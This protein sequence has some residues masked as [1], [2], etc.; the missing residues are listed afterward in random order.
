VITV[1]HICA[2]Y[3]KQRL[4]KELVSALAEIGVNQ[5]ILVPVRTIGEVGAYDVQDYRNVKVVYA[6][7]L[8]NLDRIFFFR[9]INRIYD[10][11]IKNKL[12]EGVDLVH[13]HFLFSDGGVGYLLKTRLNI[14]FITAVRNTDLNVFWKYLFHLRSFGL[15]IAKNSSNLIFISPAYAKDTKWQSFRSKIE[16]IPNGIK[17]SWF[18][19]MSVSKLNNEAIK[20]L[21][22]GDFTR[23]KNIPLLL[24][25]IIKLNKRRKCSLTLV[26]GGGDENRILDLLKKEEYHMVSYIGRINNEDELKEI[27]CSHDSLILI[28]KHETFGLV[29]IEALSQGL[30]IIFTANQ[31][32][33]GYFTPG[34]FAF[35]ISLD[36]NKEFEEAV[37]TIC[38]NI[39]LRRDKAQIASRSFEWNIIS[40]KYLQVYESI[41]HEW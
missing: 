38:S 23:N 12:V 33:D 18:H 25:W 9:K 32:V 22:V 3:S 5:I 8:N 30:P 6:H 17:S 41:I 31:G 39:D 24:N 35:P 13:A 19:S 27:Y 10:Y 4:Y 34:E 28:S 36:S 16:V 7:I 11:I 29:C 2:D 21:Y 20:L 14:P 26:G 1:L 37:L 15:K 40:K